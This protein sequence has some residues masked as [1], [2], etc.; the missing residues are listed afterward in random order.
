MTTALEATR[1]G[2]RYGR[3]WALQDCSLE[4]PTQRVIGLVGPNGAGKTTLLHL[5]VGLL[6]PTAGSVRVLGQAPGSPAALAKLGFVAQDKPL[7]KGFTVAETLKMGGWMNPH[8]DPEPARRRLSQ[9]DIPMGLRVGKL[10]GGQQAQ[11]ALGLALGKQPELLLLDEPVANLD[12]LA[13]RDFLRVLM[14][15]VAESGRTV[16]LSSHLIADLDRTCDY[17]VL[18]SA[19]RV[20]LAG[21]VDE[22]LAD[23]LL[24]SGPSAQ[25]DAIR[26]QHTVVQADCA[27]RQA[28]LLI[29]A[30][31]PVLD[32][33]WTVRPP[34]MEELVL[35]YMGMPDAA[36]PARPRLARSATEVSA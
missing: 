35:A 30:H 27:E 12:P 34:T 19:S 4:L 13:R 6:R 11:V 3:R 1:L 14:E 28:V 26:A 22:L 7:Y 31:G 8:W 16:V 15:D 32:P 21:E 24:L 10:S 23:H 29:R 33:V 36:V 25:V 18:L 2:R 17:L 9:L 20:Q 5:A